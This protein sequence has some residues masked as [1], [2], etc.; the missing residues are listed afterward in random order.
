MWVMW[1]SR[2]ACYEEFYLVGYNV[3]RSGGK[4]EAARHYIQEYDVM[5]Y[6]VNIIHITKPV[7]LSLCLTSYALRHEVNGEAAV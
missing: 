7:R 1:G 4:Q 2:S 3:L 5:L 6:T